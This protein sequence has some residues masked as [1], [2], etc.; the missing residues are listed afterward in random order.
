[1]IVLG[2]E[3][4][5][6]IG[7]VA[8]AADEDVLAAHLFPEGSRHARDVMV[9]VDSVLGEAALS[10]RDVDAVAVSRGPGSFTGLRIGVTC[11]KTLAYALGWQAVGVPTLQVKVQNVRASD[12]GEAAH[13]CPV[14]DARRGHVYGTIF[15]WVEDGWHDTTGVLLLEPHELARMLPGDTVVFGSGVVEYPDCFASFTVAPPECGVARAEAVCRL[16]TRELAEGGAVDPMELMPRY[17][18]L[19]APEERMQPGG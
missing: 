2:I 9:A 1:M 16:G 15:E 19:T 14:Q 17:H 12:L 3:T 4:S 8:V 10:K 5:G 7:S 11:A 13:A 18:R 6:P